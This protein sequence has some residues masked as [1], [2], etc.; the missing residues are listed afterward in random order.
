MGN[1]QAMFPDCLA[2]KV[3]QTDKVLR[4]YHGLDFEVK[5]FVKGAKGA[6]SWHARVCLRQFFALQFC[7]SSAIRSEHLSGY[8]LVVRTEMQYVLYQRSFEL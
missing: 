1:T 4:R 8:V 5:G 7:D 2:D 3:L 6:F